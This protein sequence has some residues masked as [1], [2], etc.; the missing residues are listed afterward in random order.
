MCGIAVVLGEAVEPARRQR[1][2]RALAHR[3]PDD[4]GI[5]DEDGV[6][7]AHTRLA[8]LD[9]SEAGRQPMVSPDGR[10]VLAYNG[11]LY[12]YVE[13]REGLGPN[14]W[15]WRGTSDTEVLLAL[16]T[17]E[18]L[19]CLPRLRGMFAFALW[20]RMRRSLLLA[21]DPFGIK[22]LYYSHRPHYSAAASELRALTVLGAT[23][24]I[25]PLAVEEFLLTGS[26]QGPRTI[27][28]GV[29]ALPPGCFVEICDGEAREDRYWE[30]PAGTTH[31]RKDEEL[32]GELDELLR[33]SV[34]MEL[35]SDVPVG[36]FLS[37]GIDSSL[38]AAYAAEHLGADLRTFSVGFDAGQPGSDETPHAAVVADALGSRHERIVVTRSDFESNMETLARA[39]DQPSVDGV[40]SYFVSGAA[41]NAV[42]VALSGQGGDELF[43]GYNIYQLASRASAWTARARLPLVDRAAAAVAVRLPARAQQNWYL[44]GAL[45]LAGR[46]DPQLIHAMTNPL[47]GAGE[48]HSL[49]S[50]PPS[51]PLDGDPVN[52]LSRIQIRSYLVNT[53]LRDMDAMSMSHSL[54][55]RVP[56][57]DTRIADFALGL[58]G[59]AKVTWGH[60]KAPL[61]A[62]LRRRLPSEIVDRRKQGF[63]FPLSEWLRT[64]G[65]V[66]ALREVLDP[67]A[68]A[69][70]G[71]VEPGLAQRELE[72]LI[73]P[74]RTDLS[75]H[76]AQRVWG[77]YVLHR[78]HEYWNELR[79]GGDPGLPLNTSVRA[80]LAS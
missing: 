73:T 43:A 45:A 54:E 62:L 22:P 20:D 80:R 30:L 1:V 14:V 48:L 10:F 2:M 19:R 41:A 52:D 59:G 4:R 34:R 77:L 50:P 15:P 3:G 28:E 42:K 66:R 74:R 12:N 16:L 5:F 25:D 31:A 8:I 23:E 55:V 60:A 37:G 58:P 21:R 69:D 70:A 51:V 67:A 35:R 11:E 24:H 40:N 46:A 32:L 61:R 33:E 64:P 63:N 56:L 72:R 49:P 7:V 76:R 26:V 44:R 6:F 18:G 57:I 53:L 65:C 68:V 36:V 47:F 79:R 13:L 38:I 29:R 9:L 17:R 71:L 39:I 78:W 75:W 27:F